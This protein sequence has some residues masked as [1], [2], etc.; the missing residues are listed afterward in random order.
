MKVIHFVMEYEDYL[1]YSF[2]F[3]KERIEQ[4]YGKEYLSQEFKE[5]KQ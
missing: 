5:L 4:K 1:A 2:G 3:D